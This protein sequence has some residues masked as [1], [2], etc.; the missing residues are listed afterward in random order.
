MGEEPNFGQFYIQTESG[1]LVPFTGITRLE[2][3]DIW[4]GDEMDESTY[5][6]LT[7]EGTITFN[8]I[9]THKQARRTAKMLNSIINCHRRRMRTLKRHKEK[10]RRNGLR[11]KNTLYYRKEDQGV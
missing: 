10:E 4:I 1:E 6:S 7:H 11:A 9:Q 2:P 8:I 5:A 3:A